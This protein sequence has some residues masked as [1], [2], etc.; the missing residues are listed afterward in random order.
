MIYGIVFIIAIILFL[1]FNKLFNFIYIGFG[2]IWKVFFVCLIV[3]GGIV[4]GVISLFD[5]EK[6]PTIKERIKNAYTVIEEKYE[7]LLEIQTNL[8]NSQLDLTY[9]EMHNM[10]SNVVGLYSG[11]L[12]YRPGE[13]EDKKIVQSFEELTSLY[14]NYMALHREIVDQIE[15]LGSTVQSEESMV[16]D[17]ISQ[18][19]STL[20]T[21][22]YRID[23]MLKLYKYGSITI[24]ELAAYAE[25]NKETFE[26][27]NGYK[28]L[29]E[30]NEN[31]KRLYDYGECYRL[32]Q[33]YIRVYSLLKETIKADT[34]E[35]ADEIANV[36]EDVI[37]QLEY[38]S[39]LAGQD[40][41]DVLYAFLE[42]EY[43]RL[44]EIL[45]LIKNDRVLTATA[46][47]EKAA[48]PIILEATNLYLELIQDMLLPD[49]DTFSLN[50]QSNQKYVVDLLKQAN[51]VIEIYEKYSHD[52]YG[53]GRNNLDWI[54]DLY[55]FLLD[56]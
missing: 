29:L 4:S 10:Q 20:D 36:S 41:G 30:S 27:A 12:M 34:S 7:D 1:I 35:N 6:E 32:S 52:L 25:D 37:V 15:I 44:E 22:T 50:D 31:L 38:I 17:I 49:Y 9:N 14:D 39:S 13:S 33:V 56:Y 18:M 46:I 45:S 23:E 53:T 5:H 48:D 24:E 43:D 42:Q 16:S 2:A 28:E 19:S 55:P 51:D 11:V 3:S 21:L 40:L 8:E 54:Y 47:V 26:E